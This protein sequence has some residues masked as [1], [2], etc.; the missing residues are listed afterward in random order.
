MRHI[1]TV[2]DAQKQTFLIG[3]LFGVVIGLQI[4]GEPITYNAIWQS[5]KLYCTEPELQ[6]I[7]ETVEDYAQLLQQA[8]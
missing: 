5:M 6:H 3:T 8:R 7:F 4:S 2:E 1:R